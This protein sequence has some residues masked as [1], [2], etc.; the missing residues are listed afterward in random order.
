[1]VA[2]NGNSGKHEATDPQH[3]T[4]EGLTLGQYLRSERE[5]R[6]LTIEELHE[7]TGIHLSSLH[8]LEHDLRKE[9][10]ADVFVRGFIKLYT[11]S[12][13]LDPQKALGLLQ[14][15]VGAGAAKG[16]ESFAGKEILSSESLAESPL[17]TRKKL[18]FCLLLILLGLLAYIVY[19]DK[20]LQE[21]KIFPAVGKE[22]Y[23]AP[24]LKVKPPMRQRNSAASKKAAGSKPQPDKITS[25]GRDNAAVTKP[26]GKIA[27][28]SPSKS[29][30]T[31]PKQENINAIAENTASTV[32]KKAL[33]TLT[34][35]FT[36]MTWVH[37]VID[38]NA[39]KEALFK[40]GTTATWQAKKNIEIV[41][42]NAG[43]V[44]LVFDG[45]P[46]DLHG[47]ET[48]KV[49]RLSFPVQSK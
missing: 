5:R 18:L 2:S 28:S 27:S 24:P 14:G 23:V 26:A 42:G 20:P 32:D 31:V 16:S 40:P 7:K 30:A 48:G 47:K 6:Q 21:L 34:A 8:A 3:A 46:V 17:F 13:N 11:K 44:S 45:S 9:L 41:L 29:V 15:K 22:K 25:L 43:G 38:H 36:Q 12:L 37:T 35:S 10:P 33:H 39:T 1:M 49:L 19:R 4:P